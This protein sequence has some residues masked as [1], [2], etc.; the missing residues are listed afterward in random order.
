MNVFLLMSDEIIDPPPEFESYNWVVIHEHELP[1]DSI[2]NSQRILHRMFVQTQPVFII[3]LGDTDVWSKRGVSSM[4]H[5]FRRLWRHFDAMALI[6]EATLTASFLDTG[7]M[8]PGSD[9]DTPLISVI[10]STFRS[11]NKLM[12]AYESLIAQTY[13]NWE[14]VLWDDSPEQG[15]YLMLQELAA[16]DMRLRVFKAPQRS[17]YIGE[18]KLRAS[19]LAWGQWLLELDHDDRLPVELLEWVRDIAVGYPSTKFIYSDGVELEEEGDEPTTYGDY[20]GYFH[21]SYYRQHVRSHAHGPLRPQFVSRSAWLN[22]LTVHHLVGLPNHVRIWNKEF[23]NEIGGHR[24]DLN[25]ADDYDLLVRTFLT[26]Q[27]REIVCITAPGYFQYRNT[28]GNNF[29]V[30]R[31]ALIQHLVKYLH[32][33]YETELATKFFTLGW[34]AAYPWPA[35]GIWERPDIPDIAPRMEFYYVPEDQEPDHPCIA[36]VLPTQRLKGDG[37]DDLL[38]RIVGK[39]AQQSYTNWKLYLIGNRDDELD[40]F[41]LEDLP[42]SFDG[43]LD[44]IY[45]YNLQ[46]GDDDRGQTAIAYAR[47]MIVKTRWYMVFDPTKE[48]E[49]NESYLEGVMN[50]CRLHRLEGG[51]PLQPGQAYNM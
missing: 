2:V 49:W 29:T 13:D 45:W 20:Y 16:S 44:Q 24:R 27:P 30:K 41:A 46:R 51:C 10:T 22:P 15:T 48:E 33:M 8:E 36:I 26:A 14:W 35:T 23:Y 38:R 47:R 7:R 3:S 43:H 9:T 42:S 4:P 40:R 28:G 5:S 19:A 32:D 50:A 34:P 31:N 37:K 12:R 39:I 6:T 21:G 11:G 17:G 25:V 18:M 1:E